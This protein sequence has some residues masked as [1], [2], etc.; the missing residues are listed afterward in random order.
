M[1]P[2][3]AQGQAKHFSSFKKQNVIESV[4]MIDKQRW[5]A[6]MKQREGKFQ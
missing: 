2:F 3:L 6:T 5:S 1:T 4:V